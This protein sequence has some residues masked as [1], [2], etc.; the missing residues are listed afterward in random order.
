MIRASGAR[1]TCKLYTS[2]GVSQD[3][4]TRTFRSI[5]ILLYHIFNEKLF[6]N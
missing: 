1:I 3:D 5:F 6:V 2:R 4:T